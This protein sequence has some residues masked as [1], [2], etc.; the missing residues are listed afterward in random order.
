MSFILDAL[1]KSETDRQRQN[2]PALYEVKLA[3]PR[4][5]LPLWAIV[6]GVVLVANLGLVMWVL[7]RSPSHDAQATAP[8]G[9]P[10]Q[11][12]APQPQAGPPLQYAPNTAPQNVPTYAP[13]GQMPPQPVA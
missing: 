6:L 9:A 13:A 5:Q 1:K 8:T 2:G 7:C 10:G 11:A 3:T 12:Y 4:T